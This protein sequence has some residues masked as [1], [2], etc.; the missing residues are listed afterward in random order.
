MLSILRDEL[1][2][3]PTR[4]GIMSQLTGVKVVE[5][6]ALPKESTEKESSAQ[7]LIDYIIELH[8][9]VYGPGHSVHVP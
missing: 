2:D 9:I 1:S 6:E 4:E 8:G 5:L 3:Q 7:K